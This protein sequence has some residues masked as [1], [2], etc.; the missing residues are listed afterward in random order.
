MVPTT[1][2]LPTG[3][4]NSLKYACWENFFSILQTSIVFQLG[5]RVS[6]LLLVLG[7]IYPGQT[8][9]IQWQ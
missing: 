7:E 9:Q 6:A 4:Q 1:G 8:E 2:R 3:H 5:P